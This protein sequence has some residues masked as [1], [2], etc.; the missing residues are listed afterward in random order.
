MPPV[1]FGG[2][3]SYD[4]ADGQFLLPSAALDHAVT[5]AYLR[6]EQTRR[7]QLSEF[8]TVSGIPHARIDGSTE[9]RSA[10]TAMTGTYARVR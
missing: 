10:L 2:G 3:R 4:S 1:G 5:A 8:L 7:Q 9:I 6:A